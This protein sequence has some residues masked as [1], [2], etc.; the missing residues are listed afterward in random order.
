MALHDYTSFVTKHPEFAGID[1]D[2]V[3]AYLTEGAGYVASADDWGDHQLAGHGYI[4]AHLLA[5]SPFG[6]GTALV[7][8]DGTTVYEK[9][10][11][12]IVRLVASGHRTI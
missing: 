2:M 6:N 8:K 10:W 3:Q 5:L 4:T 11:N 12:R 1:A 9:A 7:H